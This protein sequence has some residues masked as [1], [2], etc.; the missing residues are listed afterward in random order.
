MA[1]TKISE[2]SGLT[3]DNLQD[4]DLLPI[5]DLDENNDGTTT[6]KVTKSI[7]VGDLK[8]S[9][10]GSPSLTGTPTA[11]TA[12]AGADTTQI[13][14]TEFVTAAVGSN[15]FTLPAASA[16][17]LGGIKVGTNLSIDA[18][19]VLSASGSGGGGGSSTLNGLT[20][21]TITSIGD[22]EII[23][24]DNASS[25]Y[26]NKTLEEAGIATIA[27]PVF[28][29]NPTAATPTA[30][31]HLTTKDYVDSQLGGVAG[32][33]VIVKKV[34][35]AQM[36]G[37]TTNSN[38]WIEL[39][40]APGVGNFIA[41]R[42]FECYIDRGGSAASGVAAWKPLVSGTIRGFNDDVQLAFRT[43]YTGT[44]PIYEYNTFGVLQKGILN[45]L[46]NNAFNQTY[47]DTDIILVRDSP[48]TQTRAYPN[49]PLLL[50]PKTAATTSNFHT[51]T[52]TA[53][54]T[55]N[56][57]YYLRI[58]YRVMSLSSHFTET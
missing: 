49:V 23:S 45:H 43:T 2:L 13:A 48:V 25:K 15:S 4:V 56:D 11:P 52:S 8:T 7:T 12:T 58:S 5:V 27:S 28:T 47:A 34:T 17:T 26:V 33:T 31:T 53:T 6:D 37:L 46:I 50:K 40:P 22:G 18:D 36:S 39:I 51:Y 20:D 35:G 3:G 19:G 16:S 29:G 32:N 10:F 44:N 9:L 24:Y 21:T 57:D 42:E 55:L 30:N 38:S 41:V 1:N 14:T 54:H